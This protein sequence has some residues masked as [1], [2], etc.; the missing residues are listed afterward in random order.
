MN[1]YLTDSR[2]DDHPPVDVPEGVIVSVSGSG[3][4]IS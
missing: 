3:K 4:V 1:A 2:P